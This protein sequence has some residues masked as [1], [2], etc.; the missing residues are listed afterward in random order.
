MNR[1]Q[2]YLVGEQGPELFMP[3]TSGQVL[4]NAQTQGMMGGNVVLKDVTIGID[5]FGGLA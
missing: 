2:P 5:S 4:N 3:G 1:G